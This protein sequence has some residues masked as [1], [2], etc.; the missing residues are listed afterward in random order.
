VLDAFAVTAEAGG[1]AV[2][3]GGV[4]RRGSVFGPVPVLVRLLAYE[5]IF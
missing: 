5:V 2:E 1:A 4:L 3:N